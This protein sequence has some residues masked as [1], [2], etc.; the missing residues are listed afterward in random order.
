MAVLF[1]GL[2]T[3]AGWAEE[4]A[5]PES[6]QAT[7]E[8][9]PEMN[10]S[11]DGVGTYFEAT[12]SKGLNVAVESIETINLR[13]ESVPEMVTM[14][15]SAAS[16]TTATATQ[17][18]LKGFLPQTTYYK[19]ED[20]YKSRL[21]FTTDKNGEYAYLQDISKPHL[22]FI[23]PRP[24]TIF[25][26]N[27]GW[28][29]GGIGTW[30]PDTKTATLTA[31]VYETI[32]VDSDGIILDGNGHTLTGSGTGHGIYLSRRTGVTVKNLT[33]TGFSSGF[34]LS[35]STGNTLVDN[36]VDTGNYYGIW[37]MYS[38]GNKLDNNTLSNNEVGILMTSCK[39]N[40][41]T[42][43]TMSNNSYNFD[44]QAYSDLEYAHNINENNLVDG[45][46]VYY[47]RNAV[48]QIV[49]SSTNAGTVY[50]IN[51]NN[52]TVRNLTL[53]KN[54]K[55]IC[56]WKTIN[57]QIENVTAAN[58]EH[59][60]YLNCSS[61]NTLSYNQANENI[62][63][64]YLTQSP[65]NKLLNN[66]A[67]S[68]KARGIEVVSSSGTTLTG[69]TAETNAG[70]AIFLSG[71]DHSVLTSNTASGSLHGIYLY[72]SNNYCTLNGNQTLNNAERGI[73]I[74]NSAGNTLAGNV[75]SGN[76]YNFG[77]DGQSD[78]NGQY[79]HNIDTSNLVDGKPVYYLKGVSGQTIDGLSNAGTVYCINCD[80]ITI[81][82]VVLAKNYAGIRFVNTANS[83]IENITVSDNLYGVYLQGSSGN[84]L[85]GNTVSNNILHGVF[86]Y[87]YSNNN[88][89]TGNKVNSNSYGLD[90]WTSSGNTLADND[91]SG[92]RYGIMLNFQSCGNTINHN[93]VNASSS[94]GLT[95]WGQS[96]NN[97]LTDNAINSGP[98]LGLQVGN[99]GGNILT[100]NTMSGNRL[101][102]YVAGST[103]SE[104][105]NDIDTSNLVDGKPI[106][107]VRNAVG[108]TVDSSTN[109]GTVYLI[110]CDSITVRDLNLAQ[111][112]AGV[113]L[114]G[115]S[116][117]K[118]E[119]VVISKNRYG[120]LVLASCGNTLTGN[121]F[122]ANNY[123]FCFERFSNNNRV[124]GNSFFNNSPFVS[125]N[126]TGNVFNL[127]TGGNHWSNWTTPDSDNDG[128]V[129]SPYVFAGGED[130]LPLVTP[131]GWCETADITPPKTTVALSGALGNGG[132]YVSDVTVALAAADNEGGSGVARTEYSFDGTTWNVYSDPF[133]VDT[134]GTT[135]VY[136]RST[137]KAGNIETAEEEP[138][139]IDK[140]APEIEIN[141]PVSEGEY[142]RGAS[143]PANWAATDNLSGIGEATG[144]VPSGEAIDT[145]TVGTKT[146]SVV[147]T[148][149]AGNS[150][151]KT[152]TYRVINNPPVLNPIGDQDGSE[153]ELL[154]FVVTA[155]D[156]DVGDTLILSASNLPPGASFDPVTGTFS[157]TPGY[158]QAGAYTDVEFTVQDN[159]DPMALDFELIT[160]TSGNVNRPPEFTPVGAQEVLE[161]D[162]LQFSVEAVDP[163]GDSVTYAS[164][165]LPAGASFDPLQAL[166][167]WRPDN[168]QAGVYSVVFYATD[169]G[170]PNLTG[171]TEVVIT[172]GDVPTPMELAELLIDAVL[173]YDLPKEV[174][175]SY[176]ANLKKVSP[177]I[178][179]GKITP[180]I[181]QLEAFI[182]KVE[183]DIA[184]G[185]MAEEEGNYLI[186]MA[187]DLIY[188]LRSA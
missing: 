163:D 149:I 29:Q 118:I 104:Y 100:G 47:I 133:V 135:I 107:Y 57:S 144:T 35:S 94:S 49:D 12:N 127:A 40:T 117:S 165:P 66:T 51:C 106:Y 164:G 20:D 48:S 110:N 4:W 176:L 46:P 89:L 158:D 111:N 3:G 8:T 41:L 7:L 73:Y 31:D 71:S 6:P 30:D 169:N 80:S 15:V 183:Q 93:S 50:L 61:G 37:L 138:M 18:T 142:L 177:F 168:S 99:A 62:C 96:G 150:T 10:R 121:V 125:D 184:H 81:K 113:C 112:G 126:S 92:N 70:E 129:D 167:S 134:E 9:N 53:A 180:A 136:Y 54:G 79:D 84:S 108:Q 17:I 67:N 78:Y 22:I 155:S 128:F 120:I 72:T 161:N 137:D 186:G 87:K 26:S 88:T 172:V 156:P 131:T 63:G 59:G 19:Y 2:A 60:I 157:W 160:I 175:N 170:T 109:A 85:T 65:D 162:L 43:N 188:I 36:V 148:D 152:V 32:Q 116:N 55:G 34:T 178:D 174:E 68:N 86:L 5:V 187:T 103:D 146:F 25:L 91:C 95:L 13:L 105:E 82:D 44:V 45:K 90:L 147:A 166:F 173:S 145:A 143:V 42:G 181:A 56:L 77:L 122:C 58:N 119:D 179:M 154:T 64:I 76:R 124:Y 159:G 141:V 33:I 83:T 11:N 123:G 24:S 38:D 1:I 27:S 151:T 182:Q 52:V 102:F 171:Q 16:T 130:D 23:Q 115:T 69:N 185:K 21:A 97:T 139:Y 39:N 114:W 75:M 14:Y 101:N 28:S 153:G 74:G 140:T 98:G 132:W